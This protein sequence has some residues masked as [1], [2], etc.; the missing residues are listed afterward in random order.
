M[1]ALEVF[2]PLVMQAVGMASHG[3]SMQM[4]IEDRVVPPAIAPTRPS[5]Q[6]RSTVCDEPVSLLAGNGPWPPDSAVPRS[7]PVN[8]PMHD[9]GL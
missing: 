6:R 3:I 5:G 8:T 9:D 2:L 1:P 4:L 7:H